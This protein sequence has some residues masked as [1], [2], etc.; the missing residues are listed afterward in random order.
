MGIPQ[1]EYE[2]LILGYKLSFGF[3]LVTAQSSLPT[4]HVY[5]FVM[6]LLT[7]R[8]KK[9]TQCSVCVGM[10]CAVT[11]YVCVGVTV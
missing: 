6:L 9:K 3:S 5:V 7:V 4:S 8:N 11:Q 2:E 1:A 10:T